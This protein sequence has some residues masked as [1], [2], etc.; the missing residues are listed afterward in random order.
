MSKFK[1]ITDGIADLLEH[2][3]KN[4][5]NAV[6]SPLQI[7]AG[8]TKAGV[9][10]DDKLARIKNSDTLRKNDVADVLGYMILICKENGWDDFSE[11]KD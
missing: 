9:R 8:K 7:F 2:K 6:L 4:Y 3:N 1:K 10:L 11:F 5:G